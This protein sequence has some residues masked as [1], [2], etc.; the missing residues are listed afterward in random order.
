MRKQDLLKN[1]HTPDEDRERII[2]LF[3]EARIKDYQIELSIP[4]LQEAFVDF[5]LNDM[6]RGQT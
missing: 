3:E 1:F 4:P 5:I 2:K 6:K